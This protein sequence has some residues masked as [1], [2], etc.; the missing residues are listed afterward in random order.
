M[1]TDAAWEVATEGGSVSGGATA[2]SAGAEAAVVGVEG[3]DCAVG[4]ELR[5]ATTGRLAA[6]TGGRVGVAV[7][8]A[9]RAP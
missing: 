9:P 1:G 6:V 8:G 2:R 3:C 4:A 7:V 5:A